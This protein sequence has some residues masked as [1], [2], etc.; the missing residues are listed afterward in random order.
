MKTSE[1]RKSLL[2][3]TLIIV[4]FLL[5]PSHFQYFSSNEVFRMDQIY[6]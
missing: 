5:T 6:S 3:N 2:S 4:S 1:P